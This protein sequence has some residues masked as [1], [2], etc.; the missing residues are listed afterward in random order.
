MNFPMMDGK[1]YY[2]ENSNIT[3]LV[4]TTDETITG[5]G[6]TVTET[7]IGKLFNYNGLRNYDIDGRIVY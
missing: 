4:L 3:N 6:F 1:Y 7:F 5:A 2:L